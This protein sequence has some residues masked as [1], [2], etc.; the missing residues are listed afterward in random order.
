MSAYI[1]AQ[2]KVHDLDEYRKYQS[3]FMAVSKPFGVRVLV[4]TDDVL[5]GEWPQIR[6]VN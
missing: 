4:A 6:T 1:V 5:E 2:I 3:G